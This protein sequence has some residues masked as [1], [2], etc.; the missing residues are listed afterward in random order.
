[1]SIAL[2]LMTFYNV[3]NLTMLI[4]LKLTELLSK[5]ER[6]A[7]HMLPKSFYKST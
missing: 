1:M 7:V 5:I 6:E 3:Q 4:V 2:L